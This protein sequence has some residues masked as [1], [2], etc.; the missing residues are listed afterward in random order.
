[1]EVIRPL[2]LRV[3]R[4]TR[5]TDIPLDAVEEGIEWV[6]TLIPF[7]RISRIGLSMHVPE[8]EEEYIRT[9]LFKP[10]PF[11]ADLG[12]LATKRALVDEEHVG[13][14]GKVRSHRDNN[15]LILSGVALNGGV[16]KQP[17][18]AIVRVSDENPI[19]SAVISTTAHEIT[20]LFNVKTEGLKHDGD[21]HCLDPSCLMTETFD[22]NDEKIILQDEFC[23]ECSTQLH[24]N[25]LTLRRIKAKL[26]VKASQRA[27]LTTN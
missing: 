17:K 11:G 25:A 24:E 1:M 20:H 7:I 9:D 23:D 4:D 26:P 16:L 6:R 27:K 5:G 12:I 15:G 3:F 19:D 2:T 21:G 14:D 8:S 10:Q 22:N 18:L 13:K